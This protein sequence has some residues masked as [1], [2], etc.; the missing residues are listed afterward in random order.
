MKKWMSSLIIVLVIIVFFFWLPS[1][2]KGDTTTGGM[3]RTKVEESSFNYNFVIRNVQLYDG[4]KRYDKV[5]ILVENKRIKQVSEVVDN[6]RGYRELDGKGKTLIP[7]LIDAHTHT[8]GDALKQA[9][10][11]GVTTELD[12]FTMPSA[13]NPHQTIRDDLTNVSQADLFSATI[14]ATAPEG[15]GTEYGFKIPVLNSVD[16][17]ESFVD[18]RINEGADYIKVV[19]QSSESER[20][21]YP[22]ISKAILS[23][24]I[25][26]THQRH[27]LIVVHVDDLISATE[28]IELGADGIIHSFMDKV[29][30]Q[31]FI[32]LMVTNKAF[33][34]PTLSVEASVAGVGRGQDLSKA[35]V[36]EPFLSIEQRQQLNV[37]FQNYGI[38]TSAYE[39]AKQSVGLLSKAGVAV[40]AGTDAPNPGT[41]HGVS[42]HA[43]LMLLVDAGLTSEQA[44][45]SSTGAV[46]KIFPV[47]QRGTLA[48]G[49][50]ASMILLKGNPFDDI[51]NTQN[52][53]KIWKNGFQIT[54][55]L[56]AEELA[57]E[58]PLI[59]TVISDFNKNESETLVGA[60]INPTTDQYA[61]GQSAV[62][63][64]LVDK[65]M[66]DKDTALLVTGEVKPGF[67]YPWSGI[68]FLPGKSYTEGANLTALESIGFD[69]KG[70]DLFDELTVLVF[71]QGSFQPSSQKVLLDKKWQSYDVD[72]T[73]FKSVDFTRITNISFVATGKYGPFEFTIDNLKFE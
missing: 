13:S 8:W 69:A 3:S 39:K 17:V 68:A 60:G 61:G 73:E 71:Q 40:I 31:S 48:I 50:P 49:A 42:I 54:R 18:E 1:P 28:T 37:T 5:D 20:K 51:S 47:G 67:A 25:E 6:V 11:F 4:E 46:G 9:L 12:M 43:E 32:N 56:A 34:I 66:G 29:V 45:Y 65:S 55:V 22:S 64:S 10:N 59:A 24:L 53:D 44:L 15:H 16:Q 52:I 41:A 36:I 38:P 35:S 14:L 62:M 57:N 26:V 72:M 21:F 33:I 23:R 30:D 58:Q 63:V 19:Y 2:E 7:G 70:S 27:K